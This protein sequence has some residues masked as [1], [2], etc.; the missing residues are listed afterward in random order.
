MRSFLSDG[1]L[2]RQIILMKLVH[3]MDRRPAF[4]DKFVGNPDSEIQ[5]WIAR[6]GALIDRVGI[7][8]SVDF[9]SAMRASVQYWKYSV[10]SA[11]RIVK[12]AIESIR[13]ELEIY[14]D[15][16]VGR[17]FLAGEEFE[18]SKEILKIIEDS[19]ISIFVVDPYFDA[20]TF[21]LMFSSAT[22]L[23]ID[24][25]CNKFA[26]GVG[27]ISKKFATNSTCGVQIRKA[28]GIHDRVLIVD[29]ND[30]WVFGASIKDGGKKPTYLLPIRPDLALEKIAIYRG[31]WL[32]ASAV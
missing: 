26:D 27:E 20:A 12:K 25:L 21:T 23:N 9:N 13:L 3:E 1:P 19:K 10:E 16:D 14:Q 30:C 7:S 15:E 11:L 28:T 8:E 29:E 32:T 31:I 5:L 2:Q 18:F 24:I 6:V 4:G 17:V 22:N